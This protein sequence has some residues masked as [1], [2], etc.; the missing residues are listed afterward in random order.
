MGMG[1]FVADDVGERPARP[2]RPRGEVTGQVGQA[3]PIADEPVP[4]AGFLEEHTHE[5]IARSDRQPPAP[6]R[7]RPGALL[8]VGSLGLA[9][10][11]LLVVIRGVVEPRGE[12]GKIHGGDTVESGSVFF[13]EF[14]FTLLTSMLT[15]NAVIS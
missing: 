3:F 12:V 15:E 2:E 13:A 7:L 4:R 8:V 5:S 1:I 6:P 11:Q 9:G 10:G 14:N